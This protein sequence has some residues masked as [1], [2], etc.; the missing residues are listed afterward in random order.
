L[1]NE[2]LYQRR[3]I[4]LGQMVSDAIE[5]CEVAVLSKT[6]R[7]T[8]LCVGDPVG[9]WRCD[10]TVCARQPHRDAVFA[11][12]TRPPHGAGALREEVFPL[13]RQPDTIDLLTLHAGHHGRSILDDGMDAA[14]L[15]VLHASFPRAGVGQLTKLLPCQLDQSSRPLPWCTRGSTAW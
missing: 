4:L 15:E 12:R 7:R 10:R 13:P 8:S 3:Q 5:V 11:E 2:D 9:T 6:V 1:L 14:V